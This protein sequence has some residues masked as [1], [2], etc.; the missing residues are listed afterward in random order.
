MLPFGVGEIAGI[1]QLRAGVLRAVLARPHRQ[2]LQNQ[3]AG[4]ESH[5]T[6]A[7]QLLSGRTLREFDARFLTG[8]FAYR[9]TKC[10]EF[11]VFSRE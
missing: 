8:D 9:C 1:T 3:A 6:H 4:L 7:M 5:P 11:S 10:G 2:P